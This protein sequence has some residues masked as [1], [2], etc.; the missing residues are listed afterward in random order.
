[1]MKQ[2]IILLA[3]FS[4][5]IF[6]AEA[7]HVGVFVEFPNNATYMQCVDVPRGADAYTVLEKT[8][9][10][11]T[12]TKDRVYGHSLCQVLDYGCGD[13]G[14]ICSREYWNFY[15]QKRG[16]WEYSS[17]GFDGG[18][19]C[20]TH[21]CAREDDVLGFNFNAGGDMPENIGFK[22]ICSLIE[23]KEVSSITGRF[24]SNPGRYSGFFAIAILSVMFGLYLR[25]KPWEYI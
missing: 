13:T 19:S 10:E 2:K 12:W 11:L 5:L 8:D 15:V 16:V 4:A 22:D 14:C 7:V 3:I 20:R 1:M 25:H 17:V 9:L 21:Y 18:G 24:I 23:E 6:T